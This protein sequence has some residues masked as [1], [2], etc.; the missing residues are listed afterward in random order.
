[1]PQLL[2]ID[3]VHIYAPNRLVAEQWYKKVLGF[4]R[5]KTLECWFDVGGPLTIENGGV[6]IALFESNELTS[7]TVAFAVDAS[8]Y[9][10][11][12]AHLSTFGVIFSESDHE[13][14]WSIYFRDPYGNPFEIT[15]Y[16]Y[17]LIK[18]SQPLA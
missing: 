3:H 1:M 10:D 2:K 8:N 17:E 12:K 6:H 7:T 4:K 16:D 9:I 15:S 11:W 5:V 13:L 18:Q 14:S